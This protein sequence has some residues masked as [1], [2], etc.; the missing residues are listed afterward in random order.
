M[1]G[2]AT[3]EPYAAEAVNFA[4]LHCYQ[5]NVEIEVGDRHI[6]FSYIALRVGC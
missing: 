5:R 6:S 4:R 1:R 2:P 3:A